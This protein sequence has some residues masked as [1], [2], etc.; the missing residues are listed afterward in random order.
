M[1]LRGGKEA[2][3]RRKVNGKTKKPPRKE[4]FSKY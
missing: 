4:A 2:G 3:G 1:G